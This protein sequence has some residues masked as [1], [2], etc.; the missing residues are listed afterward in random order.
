LIGT[1]TEAFT[2]SIR[3]SLT[4]I[5]KNEGASLETCLASVQGVVDE[6][7]IVVYSLR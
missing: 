6:I 4:M 3:T 5:V 1:R 2:M 7:I